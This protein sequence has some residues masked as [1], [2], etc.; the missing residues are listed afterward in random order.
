MV[1]HTRRAS[2]TA[3]SVLDIN[4]LLRSS[5]LGEIILKEVSSALYCTY[6]SWLL[7]ALKSQRYWQM[8]PSIRETSPTRSRHC[9][10]RPPRS[11]ANKVGHNHFFLLWSWYSGTTVS[12]HA[13]VLSPDI[14]MRTLKDKREFAV[15]ED[16]LW[17][18]QT[19]HVEC[20]K[21]ALLHCHVE[22]CSPRWWGQPRARLSSQDQGFLGNDR[23]WI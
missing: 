21:W 8:S 16:Y 19:K 9:L 5:R 15:Q 3:V 13:L 14:K 7:H 1:R 18:L 6:G 12:I 23:D 20:D 11:F 2:K 4:L 10:I 22:V 17:L